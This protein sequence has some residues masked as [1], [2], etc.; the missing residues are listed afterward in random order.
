MAAAPTLP[1]LMAKFLLMTVALGFRTPMRDVLFCLVWAFPFLL[2]TYSCKAIPGATA[3]PSPCGSI[4]HQEH[5]SCKERSRR[6]DG[7]GVWTFEENKRFENALATYTGE[8]YS[9]ASL[10][11]FAEKVAPEFPR[12]SVGQVRW[13][14]EA[15][16][17][18]L[19]LIESGEIAF[20][21]QWT[22]NDEGKRELAGRGVDNGS[23]SSFHKSKVQRCKGIWT[24]GIWSKEEHEYDDFSSSTAATRMCIF[25]L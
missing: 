25:L 7:G 10:N 18:D 19:E 4:D 24:Q 23:S 1:S 15:L 13:H 17:H 12:K 8:S 22:A 16:L 14:L 3:L 9:S 21:E 5:R 2:M 20:P 11:G 6:R